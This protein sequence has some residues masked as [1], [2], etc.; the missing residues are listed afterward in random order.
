MKNVLIVAAREFRQIASDAQLLAD[1]ADPAAGACRSARSPS[2]SSSD[3][4][5]TG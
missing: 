3:D 5:P 2:A 1:P 4:A